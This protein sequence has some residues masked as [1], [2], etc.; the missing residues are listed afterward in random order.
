[1]GISRRIEWHNYVQN[2]PWPRSE[3]EYDTYDE[4]MNELVGDAK[5][6]LKKIEV[7]EEYEIPQLKN[8]QLVT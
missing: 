8:H 3:W 7:S 5:N 6:L 1:M 2:I 4:D